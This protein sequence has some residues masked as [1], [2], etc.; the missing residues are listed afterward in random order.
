MHIILIYVTV[1]YN[2]FQFTK[3]F[4]LDLKILKKRAVGVTRIIVLGL[5]YAKSWAKDLSIM[6][7]QYGPKSLLPVKAVYS[8]TTPGRKA[9]GDSATSLFSRASFFFAQWDNVRNSSS[10]AILE[11]FQA[12]TRARK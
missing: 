2:A 4:H 7:P 9:I 3:G 11:L 12:A 8:I 1:V 10:F 6:E 5:N